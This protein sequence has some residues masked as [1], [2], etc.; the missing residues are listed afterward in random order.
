MDDDGSSEGDFIFAPPIAAFKVFGRRIARNS[1]PS[2][3]GGSLSQTARLRARP[4]I[5]ITRVPRMSI[6]QHGSR[7]RIFIYS[8]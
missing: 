1:H 4:I 7:S 6:S 3:I 8:C 2:V 5:E